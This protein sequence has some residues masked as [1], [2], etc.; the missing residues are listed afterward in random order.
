MPMPRQIYF[1]KALDLNT[2]NA[3]VEID[4]NGATLVGVQLVLAS[5]SWGNAVVTFEKSID[6]ANWVGFSTAV[7]LAA[8]GA[9]SLVVGDCR[10]VRA[11]VSTVSGGSASA[12][13]SDYQS[14][15]PVTISQA[16][17]GGLTFTKKIANETRS[18]ST[19]LANDSTLL[20]DVAANTKYRFRLTVFYTT[21]AAADFKYALDGPASPT[22]VA[23]RQSHVVPGASA[24]TNQIMQSAEIGSTS[25]LS[26]TT[27]PGYITM[28]GIWH[29]GA[30]AGTLAF[31]WAQVTSDAGNTTVLAGSCL[32]WC[33]M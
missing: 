23:I 15:G 19:T 17:S 16:S 3:S 32:E 14:D 20:I 25:V 2:L 29:N 5:G 13:V 24:N 21:P 26:G 1:S 8:A 28:D 9:V 33:A 6:G 31:Q 18:A 10:Y 7:T 12:A 30:N 27:D 22:Q 11:R 4:V